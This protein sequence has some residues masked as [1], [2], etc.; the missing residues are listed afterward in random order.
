[1]V[2]WRLLGEGLWKGKAFLAEGSARQGGEKPPEV[3]QESGCWNVGSDRECRE[4]GLEG[5]VGV[6]NL[7]LCFIPLSPGQ[8]GPL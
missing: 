8:P 3:G 5:S 2:F 6:C 7:P 1:M 4:K